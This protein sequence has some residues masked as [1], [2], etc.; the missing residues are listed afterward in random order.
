MLNP[1]DVAKM[2]VIVTAA[3]VF[4]TSTFLIRIGIDIYA[5]MM[6]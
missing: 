2:M 1:D 4:F 5:D 6:Q 3:M